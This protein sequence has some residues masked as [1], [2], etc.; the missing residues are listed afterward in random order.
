MKNFNCL[1]VSLAILFTFQA[2]TS[3]NVE[4]IVGEPDPSG[5]LC[6]DKIYSFE[7]DVQPA[8]SGCFGCHSTV[9]NSSI[10]GNINLEGYDNFV[11]N[12]DGVVG[13]VNRF[14]GYSPMPKGGDKLDQEYLDI[15]DCWVE[16]GAEDN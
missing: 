14:P 11:S 3:D 16:Q 9:S 12:L 4:D 13:S 6:D 5:V 7:N 15:L 8:F 1:L 10:G 2:C